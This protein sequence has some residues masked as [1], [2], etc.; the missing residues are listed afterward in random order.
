[1]QQLGLPPSSRLSDIIDE[2]TK[3]KYW[4]LLND[5]KRIELDLPTEQG[6]ESVNEQIQL[7]RVPIGISSA[8]RDGLLE[9]TRSRLA[10]LGFPIT[11]LIFRESGNYDSDGK[12]KTKWAMRLAQNY[13]IDEVFDRD[14]VTSSMIKKNV[15]EFKAKATTD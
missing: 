2:E 12:F 11:H 6:R 10:N 7:G 13:E 4:D 9:A 1:M 3:S 5:A 8:R 14:A 15:E